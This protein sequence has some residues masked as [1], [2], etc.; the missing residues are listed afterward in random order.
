M[1][2]RSNI[3]STFLL[4]LLT[5]FCPGEEAKE[6]SASG[7]AK[8]KEATK[9]EATTDVATD[10][11]GAMGKLIPE[12]M[13]NLNVGIPGFENGQPSSLITADA[14]TRVDANSLFAEDMTIK[15]FGATPKEDVKVSLRTATYKMDEK[16]LSSQERSRVARSDF[17][18]EGDS[19]I[20]DTT[21]SQGKMVGR[22]HMV[23]YDT[24]T[25][26]QRPATP[27]TEGQPTTPAQPSAAATAPIT[28]K[29]APAP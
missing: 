13:R 23:I 6:K 7:K 16:T 11:I 25:F 20:F 27:A 3:L 5:G 19:M 17:F 9:A 2:P 21:T 18:I 29:L 4:L 22:V 1:H 26:S 8:S 24:A 28:P 12:G 15:I 14:L 10:G